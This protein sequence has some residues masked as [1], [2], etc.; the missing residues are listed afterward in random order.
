V[1]GWRVNNL[2]NTPGAAPLLV[3]RREAARLLG[4]SAGSVDNLR[5]RG[6]LP[7]IKIG[8]ARRFDMADLRRFID[9][10]KAVRP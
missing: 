8:A 7:S 4:I 6:E 2:P 1:R 9:A 10:R 3:D 5:T